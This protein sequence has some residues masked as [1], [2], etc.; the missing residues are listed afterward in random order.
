MANR[1]AKNMGSLDS[2]TITPTLVMSGRFTVT[3]VRTAPVADYTLSLW[4]LLEVLWATRGPDVGFRGLAA[5][6]SSRHAGGV[7]A[8]AAS[9]AWESASS[10][11]LAVPGWPVSRSTPPA[12]TRVRSRARRPLEALGCDLSYPW[13]PGVPDREEG[14]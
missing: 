11:H 14:R 1:P 2:Q 7:S 10:R 12:G 6:I 5:P 4:R 3:G 8:R 9:R 13:A